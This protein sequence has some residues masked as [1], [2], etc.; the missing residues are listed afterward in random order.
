MPFQQ[1]VRVLM[2][3]QIDC[4]VMPADVLLEPAPL[5][6]GKLAVN[7]ETFGCLI[8]P[9]SSALPARLL[10]YLAE[11]ADGGL[12]VLFVNA[13]PVRS[14]EG[15]DRRDT[16]RR[17]AEHP[18]VRVVPLEGL[19]TAV[20]ALGLAEI[21]S[22]SFQPALRHYHVPDTNLD[23]FLFVNEHPYQA[24]E[25]TL[26]IPARGRLLAYDALSRRL[27]GLPAVLDS[28]AAC[29][30]LALAA[31]ESVLVITGP[32]ADGLEAEPARADFQQEQR[33]DGVWDIA[34]ATAEQYP[35]FVLWREQQRLADLSRPDALPAFSGTFRYETRFTAA[36]AGGRAVL[37]LGEAFET[38]ED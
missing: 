31:Y 19:A 26:T 1:P 29:F 13:L 17:L 9:F 27:T 15:A 38:A 16:L 6:D 34:T 18:N 21:S 33:V 22:D 37:D 10:D 28:G 23:V 24:V 12:P 8:I 2:Q 4:D 7:G 32:G 11:A 25:T 3:H 30:R 35:A 14:C 20:T 36:D 5:R